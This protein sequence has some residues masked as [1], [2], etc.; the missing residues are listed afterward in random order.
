LAET[1]TPLKAIDALPGVAVGD[2]VEMDVTVTAEMNEQFLFAQEDYDQRYL[3]GG[4]ERP[5]VHPGL[6]VHLNAPGFRVGPASGWSGVAARD[7]VT[8][9]SPAYVDEPLKVTWTVAEFFEKRNRPYWVR[10][11]LVRSADDGRLVLRRRLHSTFN[12]IGAG[13]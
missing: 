12:R 13:S 9:V 10:E 1:T 11:S 7:A 8:F 4:A 3:P 2:A 5:I 6:L